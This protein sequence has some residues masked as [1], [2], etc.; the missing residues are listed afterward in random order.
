MKLTALVVVLSAMS[1]SNARA[2]EASAKSQGSC[3]PIGLTASGE[4]VF[5]WDCRSII[6]KQ[7]G[8]VSV[9]APA[10]SADPS[11]KEQASDKAAAQQPE[12]TA[13]SGAAAPAQPQVA[14]ATPSVPDTTATVVHAAPRVRPKRTLAAVASAD[15]KHQIAAQPQPTAQPQSAA[16]P[17]PTSAITRALNAL[18]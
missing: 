11:A 16:Q 17:Q 13:A 14:V 5:P 18:K 12:Q 3:M 15:K 6:E 7:R 10:P 2:E 1:L 9:N 4:V 8:P